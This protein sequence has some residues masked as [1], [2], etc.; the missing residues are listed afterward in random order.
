V[1]LAA[2]ILGGF[3]DLNRFD[4]LAAVRAFTGLVPHLDQ[5]GTQRTTRKNHQAG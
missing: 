5:S 4:T 2:S 1:T 3:G